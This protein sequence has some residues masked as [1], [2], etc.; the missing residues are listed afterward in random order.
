MDV[1]KMVLI[2]LEYDVKKVG[3]EIVKQMDNVLLSGLLYLILQ[4]LDEQY[5]DVDVQFGGVDQRKL[6]IVVKEW[7]F[8]L[9][10][11]ERVYLMNLMVFGLY[12]GKMSLSDLDSK[13]DLLD[14]LEMV[15]KKIKKVYVVLQVMEDNGLLVFIEYVLLLVSGLRGKKE[16]KVERERDGLE[17][18]VYED[19]EKI[20]EDYKNDIV[21][22]FCCDE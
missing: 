9:G 17:M 13:I 8:K 6:F 15:V 19:I 22:V 10:Y 4:V 7:L 20:R 21:S 2:I 18:L 3:V 14:L 1:Y 11:K 16:F 5:F 12:G